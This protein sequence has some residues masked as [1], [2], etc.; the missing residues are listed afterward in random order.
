MNPTPAAFG[1]I[2]Y[3]II[4]PS[5]LAYFCFNRGVELIGANRAGQFFHL[6]P[7]FGSAI[8]ILFLGERPEWFH[9][10][11]YA[12]IIAGIVIAQRNWRRASDRAD[13]LLR[14]AI[15]AA[16]S[17][18]PG[19]RVHESGPKAGETILFLHGAGASAEMWKAHRPPLRAVS[20]PLAGFPRLR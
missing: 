10:V 13:A 12:L 6:I 20:R 4:F 15:A 14:C 17:H 19:M 11:G 9:G 3:V 1:V 2:L 16:P 5:V 7:V 18:T 8:A